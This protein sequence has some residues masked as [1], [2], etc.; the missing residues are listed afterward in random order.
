MGVDPAQAVAVLRSAGA[1]AVGANCGVGPRET[2]EVLQK[3]HQ[4]DEAMWLAARPNA[5]VP[6]VGGGGAVYNV[7]PE[8]MASFTPSFLAAGAR[9]IGSC[10]G[11]TP[12]HTRAIARAVS[13]RTRERMEGESS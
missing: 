6:A 8:E 9:L 4:A 5:G 1:I 12:E 3:M 10:C 13:E 7:S 2:L 11:S